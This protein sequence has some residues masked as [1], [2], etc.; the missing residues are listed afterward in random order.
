VPIVLYLTPGASNMGENRLCSNIL[1]TDDNDGVREA[2]LAALKAQGYP[3]VGARNGRDAISKL[4]TLS[5]PTLIFLDLMMPVLNGWDVLE[6]WNK[7]P[8]FS[9]NKVV[10]I[11][12]VNLSSR[13]DAKIPR[14]T[15]D[16]LQKPLTFKSVF[17]LVQKYCGPA[18][19]TLAKTSA[20]SSLHP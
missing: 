18:G 19:V 13:V 9:E 20:D 17:D 11:S 4:A 1:I 15:V 8:E 12:A 14:N 5:G 10:T 7:N 3:A 6:V 2:L 16:R